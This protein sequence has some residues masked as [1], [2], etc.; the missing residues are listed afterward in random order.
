M[1]VPLKRQG[2]CFEANNLKHGQ[3]RQIQAAFTDEL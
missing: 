2:E 1:Y 3:H